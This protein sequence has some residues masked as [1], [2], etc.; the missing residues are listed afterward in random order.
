MLE[1]PC[2]A[3]ALHGMVRHTRQRNEVGDLAMV[4]ALAEL[5]EP[6]E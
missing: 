1:I 6:A 3:V 4:K 5:R 2:N